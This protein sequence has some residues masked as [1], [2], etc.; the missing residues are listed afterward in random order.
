MYQ[1]DQK[2]FDGPTFSF[3]LFLKS[4]G[5]TTVVANF[6]HN[7]AGFW[8]SYK[9]LILL[10]CTGLLCDAISTIGF[11]EELGIKAELNPSVRALSYAFGTT[12]GPLLGAILKAGVC[13][14]ICVYYRRFA[15]YMF[16]FATFAYFFAAWFNVWGIYLTAHYFYG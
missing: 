2:Q 3:E 12:A 16:C 15:P 4:T 10:L 5:A 8:R 1:I 6:R 9:W 7:Y 11:M 13:C 14:A